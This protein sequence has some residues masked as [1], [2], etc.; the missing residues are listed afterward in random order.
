VLI[1]PCSDIGDQ[2]VK[3]TA[4]ALA[5]WESANRDHGLQPALNLHDD[6]CRDDQPSIVID[7]VY[8]DD[9]PEVVGASLAVDWNNRPC[10]ERPRQR[11]RVYTAFVALNLASPLSEDERAAVLA[12][13]IGHALGLD[14]AR[15]C[16]GGTIMYDDVVCLYPMKTIGVDDIAALNRRFA[17]SRSTNAVPRRQDS[18]FREAGGGGAAMPS[19]WAEEASPEPQSVHRADEGRRGSVRAR[20][21]FAAHGVSIDELLAQKQQVRDIAQASGEALRLVRAHME[22][23]P[24]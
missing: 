13:E 12:H 17:E 9:R 14:H 20:D 10:A 22:L 6:A 3:A 4:R 2:T 8:W 11:C 24:N 21:L 5:M 18:N 16:N 19:R 7:E 23:R 1:A 15:R